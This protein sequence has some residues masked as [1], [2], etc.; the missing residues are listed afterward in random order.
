MKYKAALGA[1]EITREAFLDRLQADRSKPIAFG[2]DGRVSA[3]VLVRELLEHVKRE[4]SSS[5]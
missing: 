5:V 3:A 4:G 1:K 2:A